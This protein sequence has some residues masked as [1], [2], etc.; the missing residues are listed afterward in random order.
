MRSTNAGI[1]SLSRRR[2]QENIT[3]GFLQQTLIDNTQHFNLTDVRQDLTKRDIKAFIQSRFEDIKRYYRHLKLPSDWPS[4]LQLTQLLTLADVLFIYASTAMLFIGD[5]KTRDPRGQLKRLLESGNAAA[6]SGTQSVLDRLYEHVLEDVIEQLPEDRQATLPRLL[7]GTIVLAEERLCPSTLATLVDVPPDVVNGALPAFYAVVSIPAEEDDAIPIRLI[8]LSFANFLVD[9]TRCPNET[10]LVNPRTHHAFIASRCLKLMQESL[11]F[12]LCQVPSEHQHLPNDEIPGM[13]ARMAQHFPPALAYAC[14]Y[15]MR[16]LCSADTDEELLLTL[17]EFCKTRLLYWLEALSL[18]G[19][20]E[21]AVEALRSTQLLLKNASLR[22]TE[23]PALLY[24]C[25]RIVQAFYPVISTSFMEIYRTAIPYSPIESLLRSCHSA[26]VP[27]AVEVL[28]GLEKTWST[29]LA[30]RA[31]GFGSIQALS[32][33]PDGMQVACG[34]DEGPVLL[35]DA[36]T[37]A[38]L[39][40]FEGHRETARTVSFSPTGNE[41]MS[42]SDDTTVRLWDVVTGACLH[43]WTENSDDQVESVA[44]SPDGLLVACGASYGAITLRESNFPEK[45]VVLQHEKWVGTLTFATD[46]DLVSGSGDK[47]CKIWDTKTVDWDATEHTPRR[48]L[49]HS[50]EVWQVAGFP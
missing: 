14:R 35:L 22:E 9:P 48:I 18:L 31:T 28:L 19:C 41:I 2:Q 30:S 27:Q 46:G 49:T 25:E 47:S 8:H 7:L 11:K 29:T 16:H 32:F 50:S 5:E 17:E 21:I 38:Q 3:R 12:N 26:D 10:V 44:W 33:S 40:I 20:V 4:Q 36:H 24:D 15:W 45:S 13:Q 43:T 39:H 34:T 23:L 37:G 42:G 1:K 6:K